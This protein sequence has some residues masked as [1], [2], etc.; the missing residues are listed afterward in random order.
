[1]KLKYFS[2]SLFILLIFVLQEIPAQSFQTGK[3]GVVMSNFG[4]IR[5]VKDSLA[6][7]RQIDRSNI[8]AGVNSNYVFSYLLSA[9]PED[10]MKNVT[11][12]LLS[13]FEVYGSVN[14]S[15][16]TTGQSPDFLVKHN[17]YGWQG[18]GYILVK[19]TIKNRESGPLN[20]Y[21]G[22][23][24]IPQVDQSYGL[25]TIEYLPSSSIVS[26]Y[27]LPTSA[28]TG[29]K[30]LSHQLT[31]LHSIEWFSGYNNNNP[32]MF[33]WLT[34][35]QI[36]SIFDAGGDGAVTFI[37]KAQQNIA[38]GDSAI[39][40][41]GISVG[42]NESEMIA[43][44]SQAEAKYN[45]ITNVKEISSSL[46]TD[47]RL[48]QNYP[49]PFNPSITIQFSIPQSEYV[50]L[51]IFDVL[52]NEVAELVSQEL[53][54]GSYDVQFNANNLSSGVYFYQLVTGS[55]SETKKMNL[56]K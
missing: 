55:F 43:N 6:G 41:I 51:K 3:I 2:L 42:A 1:M 31:T 49:N 13:D 32:A 30:I 46:P 40:W 10:S 14:N 11:N 45:L 20:T 12:P 34:Y 18:G 35:G 56:I 44:M 33:G 21:I 39:M 47:Y 25:E 19:F 22:M 37:S 50:S 38:A 53:S 36:D 17:V 23:E 48:E 16:D 8:L 52:G 9:E 15:Y 7:L 27:R 54:A 26:I 29:Y 28:Y 4:R 5:V 24:I